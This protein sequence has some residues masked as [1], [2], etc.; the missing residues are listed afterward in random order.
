MQ[1]PLPG[2]KIERCQGTGHARRSHIVSLCSSILILFMA[3]ILSFGLEF[4]HLKIVLL[5]VGLNGSAQGVSFRHSWIQGVHRRFLDWFFI[6]VS[7]FIPC[8]LT[9]PQSGEVSSMDIL[10]RGEYLFF[11]ILIANVM[12]QSRAEPS[13]HTGS[14]FL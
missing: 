1:R 6:H 3:R 8:V 9:G 7:A 14:G 12:D 11:V 5:S 10:E 13:Q 2:A 4:G